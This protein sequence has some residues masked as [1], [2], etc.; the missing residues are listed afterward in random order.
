[1]KSYDSDD[2]YNTSFQFNQNQEQNNYTQDNDRTF[3]PGEYTNRTINTED[4]EKG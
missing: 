3:E 1:M 4:P 2:R